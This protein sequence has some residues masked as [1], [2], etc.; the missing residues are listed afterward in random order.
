[1]SLQHIVSNLNIKKFKSE[2]VFGC[3]ATQTKIEK[4]IAD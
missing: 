4:K 2:P 1:M 3:L